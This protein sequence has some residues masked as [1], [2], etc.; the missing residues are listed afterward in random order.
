MIWLLMA[1]EW[2]LQTTKVGGFLL[3]DKQAL[4]PFLGVGVHRDDTSGVLV[5]ILLCNDLSSE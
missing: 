1:Q 4:L 2:L 3:K 5:A